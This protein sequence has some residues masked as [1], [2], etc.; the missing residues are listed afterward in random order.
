MDNATDPGILIAVEGIDGAGKTT[1]VQLLAAA[2]REAGE[3]VTTSREPT[4]GLWGRKIKDSAQKGRLSLEDE[5]HAFINDRREHVAELI[6]P[7][8]A[9]GKTV[10]LDRYFYSTIAYQG[11]RG[12]DPAVLKQRMEEF[13]PIPDLVFIL[14]IEARRGIERIAFLRKDI[15]NKFEDVESLEKARV[16][17]NSLAAANIKLLNGRLAPQAIHRECLELMILGPLRAKRCAKSYGC[18]NEFMCSFRFNGTCRW[19][20]LKSRLLATH[21]CPTDPSIQAGGV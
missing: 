3:L 16:I 15:P 14:D 4:D 8:L 21:S 12:A 17:F 18:D 9:A 13:A 11:A 19:W 5:L 10:I 7:A 20:N 2:L 6:H 1:Q